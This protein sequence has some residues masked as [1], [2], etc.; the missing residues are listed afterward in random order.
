[1]DTASVGAGLAPALS[2]AGR[3]QAPPLLPYGPYFSQY[4]PVAAVVHEFKHD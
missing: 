1:M 4:F 3:G 2:F